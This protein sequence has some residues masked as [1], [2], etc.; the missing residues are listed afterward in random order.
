MTLDER[1]PLFIVLSTLPLA[2]VFAYLS[3]SGFELPRHPLLI[4]SML[5]FFCVPL[6][7]SERW[8]KRTKKMFDWNWLDALLIG[9]AQLGALIP[10]AGAT[11]TAFSMASF[12]NYNR[13]AAIKYV[14]MSLLPFLGA[15]VLLKQGLAGAN[16]E[17]STLTLCVSFLVAFIAGLLA[18]GALM[19]NASRTG[20]NG[21][22]VY[23]VLLAV[24]VIITYFVHPP[25]L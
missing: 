21:F 6:F 25:S 9:I 17:T 4:A 7:V 20:Y 19:K 15:Q 8:S 3:Q 22:L 14:L 23:R 13:E 2:G 1:M 10:G 12:R 11:V 18:I 16:A 24:A 5:I